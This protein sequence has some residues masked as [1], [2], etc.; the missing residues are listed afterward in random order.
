[1]KSVLCDYDRINNFKKEWLFDDNSVSDYYY[2]D[3]TVISIICHEKGIQDEL[4]KYLID[5]FNTRTMLYDKSKKSEA[6]K[7]LYYCTSYITNNSDYFNC[8]RNNMRT[9]FTGNMYDI[10]ESNYIFGVISLCNILYY[11]Y[12]SNLGIDINKVNMMIILSSLNGEVVNDKLYLK[13]I[14]EYNN[15]ETMEAKY[16]RMCFELEKKIGLNGENIKEVDITILN[17]MSK[18]LK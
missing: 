2:E 4:G 9:L 15:Q 6:N 7:L 8:Y 13:I 10:S 16:V 3:A 12:A 17:E 1:M 5:L 18:V 11:Y 14:E